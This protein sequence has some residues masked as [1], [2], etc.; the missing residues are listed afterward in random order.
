REARVLSNRFSMLADA[1]PTV[2]NGL[3]FNVVAKGDPRA[4]LGNNTEYD[5]LALRKTIDLSESQTMS[6][7]Y[8]TASPDGYTPHQA[9]ENG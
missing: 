5:M 8:G 9:G 6:L 4:E 3:A 1:A 7:E 2:G